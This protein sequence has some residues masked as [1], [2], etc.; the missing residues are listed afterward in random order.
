MDF[1]NDTNVYNI[2]DQFMFGNE[3]LVSPVVEQNAHSRKVYLPKTEGGWVDFWTGVKYGPNQTIDAAA[4]LD[5]IPLFVKAGSIVP[6]GPFIQYAEGKNKRC[7]RTA[8]VSRSQR[9]V[10]FVTKMRTTIS[11][12]K[13]DLMRRFQSDGMKRKTGS[14]EIIGDRRGEFPGMLKH[15]TFHVIWVGDH[16]GAGLES[17]T[18]VDAYIFVPTEKESKC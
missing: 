8:G 7:H 17:E 1:R 11:I 2:K 13:K 10:F 3:F 6:M 4:P 15:R 18:R 9:L 16:H 5:T 12:M 14:A